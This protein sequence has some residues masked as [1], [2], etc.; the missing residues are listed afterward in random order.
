[1]S[2]ATVTRT[3]AG[4]NEKTYETDETLSVVLH[5][6]PIVVVDKIRNTAVLSH[7]GWNSVTTLS[8][9][10]EALSRLRSERGWNFLPD[11]VRFDKAGQ[12]E[13]DQD[14]YPDTAAHT[15]GPLLVK[16]EG[17]PAETWGR[18]V[19]RVGADPKLV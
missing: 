9:I 6:T 4:R 3:G 19:V 5:Q 17:H 16:G 10:R 1:M 8:H 14:F 7:G 15:R 2:N 11:R 18:S 13:F 12:I